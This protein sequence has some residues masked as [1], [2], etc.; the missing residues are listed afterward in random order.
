[1][2]LFSSTQDADTAIARLKT[3]LAQQHEMSFSSSTPDTEIARLKAELPQEKDAH[4]DIRSALEAQIQ[5]N[6]NQINTINGQQHQIRDMVELHFQEIEQMKTNFRN[7]EP[8]NDLALGVRWST[9][10]KR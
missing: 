9:A 5:L 1:M 3:E 8:V 2:S 7:G 10:R 4:K 6:K